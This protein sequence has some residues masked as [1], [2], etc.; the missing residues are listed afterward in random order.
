MTRLVHALLIAVLAAALANAQSSTGR[1][2]GT[3]LDPS[4]AA[5]PAAEVTVR[6]DATGAAL[7]LQTNTAGGFLAVSLLPGYYTVEVVA[8]GFKAYTV[9]AQKVDVARET[10]LPPIVLELG[11]ASEVIVVEGGVSQVQT[12]NAEVTSVVTSDQIAELPLIGRDPLSFVSLQAGVAYSGATPTVINGQRTTFSKVTL[13]GVSIQ[14]N[15]IRSNGLDYLSSRTLL[16]QVAEF[17]VTSQNGS[18]AAGGA[19]ALK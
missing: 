8:E 13:D 7:E 15:Y 18:A 2:A 4:R 12:T 3:V 19:M 1:L 11:A 10:S 5:I 9:E 6:S 16:D 14:D 17:T